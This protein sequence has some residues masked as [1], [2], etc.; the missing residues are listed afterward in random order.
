MPYVKWGPWVNGGAPG[1]EAAALDRIETQYDEAVAQYPNVIK[2]IRK[3]ADEAVNN[4]T[5]L[6][7]DDHL[8]FSVGVNEVW[9]FLL[10]LQIQSENDGAGNYPNFKT[11]FSI[12]AAATLSRLPPY[13]TIA[14]VLLSNLNGTG[15]IV[16]AEAGLAAPCSYWARFIYT[17]GANAGTVQFQWAQNTA[18][19][20]DSKVL[21]N[22]YIIAHKLA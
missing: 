18:R 15:T 4:S 11:T 5:V 3:T 12:P 9:E 16:L 7:N 19:V 13:H 14:T 10:Y 6:Q 1:I 22:S 17:G 8:F 2:M 20:A 21:T